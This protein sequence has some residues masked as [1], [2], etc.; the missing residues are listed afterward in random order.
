MKYFLLAFSLTLFAFTCK[1][2]QEEKVLDNPCQN[3]TISLSSMET[4]YGCVNTKYGMRLNATEAFL[5]IRDQATFAANVTGSCLPVVDFNQYTLVIGKKQ[6][7]NDNTSISYSAT[8]NC[9]T[10]KVNLLVTITNNL[11]LAAPLVTWHTLLP[12]LAV[13]ETVDVAI[14]LR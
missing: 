13:N 7:I 6:L 2:N 10:K 4:Q 12:A 14:E 11:G 3:G 9:D 5:V 8:K 1:K